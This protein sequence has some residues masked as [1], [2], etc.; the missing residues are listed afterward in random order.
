MLFFESLYKYILTSAPFLLGGL[1]AAGVIKVFVNIETIKKYL[2]SNSYGSVFK[3]A[4][5]GIPL[6]LC[7]CAVIPSAVTLRK[8]GASNGAVSS[9]LISTPESGVDS[10]FMTY[11]MMDFPMTIIRPIAAFCTAFIAGISQI[12]F[13]PFE[14]KE[15]IEQTPKK[16]CCS[17]NKKSDLSF[18][19]KIKTSVKYAFNDLMDDISVW[20]AIGIIVG[21]LV[22]AF[23]PPEIFAGL[24]GT[25]ARFLILLIGIPTYI[26]ASAT[27]PIAASLIV[28]GLNPGA[29]IILL[30]VGPATNISNILVVQ[31]YIGKRG[32]L[33]NILSIAI[34][35]L[36]FSYIVDW[37]YAYFSFPLDFKIEH[38]HEHESISILQQVSGFLLVLLILKGI[39]V[40]KLSKLVR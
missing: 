15:E 7:S 30:L 8:S 3:A 17:K 4:F 27:T 28:K 20:L 26:C 13:N 21:A 34:V 39:W 23:F 25:W 14:Y 24:N 22:D 12:F 19:N 33:I 9:F 16:S 10:I 35:S 6:P 40:K 37:A 5:L 36:I 29:A 18:V 38:F 11:A 32:V 1:L 2:G 31:K